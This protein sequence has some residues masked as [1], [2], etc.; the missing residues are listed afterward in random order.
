MINYAISRFRS[1]C[2]NKLFRFFLISGLNTAFGYGVF[3]LLI[4][5]GI[6]Y[7]LAIF[8]GTFLGVL[9]NFKTIGILV[10]K[11]SNNLLIFKFF[12]VYGITYSI[13]VGC[14]ALLKHFGINV[15]F[16]GALLLIPVGLI[17]YFLNKSIVFHNPTR[18]SKNE[19]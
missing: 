5:L 1:Y 14:M 6:Y 15:Y 17:A 19:Q 7:S 8:I 11:N 18:L 13:N 2:E 3:A 12:M 10:F 16:G 9:F 4:S